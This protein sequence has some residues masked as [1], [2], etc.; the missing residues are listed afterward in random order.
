MEWGGNKD[1]QKVFDR[2]LEIAVEEKLSE[3]QMIKR[4]F[5]FSDME[6][7]EA[8]CCTYEIEYDIDGNMDF[9]GRKERRRKSWETYYEVIQ[10]R[11]KECGYNKVPEIVFWNLRNSS[12][13]PVMAI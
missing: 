10:K 9:K 5:V 7:D 4:L 12:S 2:M 6:V 3:D 1:F 11:F 13:T 8:S